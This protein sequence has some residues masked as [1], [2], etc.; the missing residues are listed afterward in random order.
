MCR[1]SCTRGDYGRARGFSIV[2]AIFLVVVLA[3]LGAFVVFSSGTQRSED[4]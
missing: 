2:A 4:M 3:L 1:N